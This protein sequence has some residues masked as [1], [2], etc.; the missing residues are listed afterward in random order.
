DIALEKAALMAAIFLRPGHAEPAAGADF[1]GKFRH[2]GVLAIGLERA[3][4]AGGDLFGEERAH[5]LAKLD[6]FGRQA[7][8]IET[9]GCGHFRI[10]PECEFVPESKSLNV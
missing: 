3:K 7:D 6:A 5:F 8:R 10:C 1:P 2:V 9:E 4:G